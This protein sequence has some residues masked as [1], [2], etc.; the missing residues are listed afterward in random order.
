[1]CDSSALMIIVIVVKY[2][3][4]QS[5]VHSAL[6]CSEREREQLWLSKLKVNEKGERVSRMMVN[7]KNKKL[8]SDYLQINTTILS[9]CY[10]FCYVWHM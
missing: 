1:M 2:F 4:F 9:H 7:Q 10:L 6:C 5:S 3:L 8:F